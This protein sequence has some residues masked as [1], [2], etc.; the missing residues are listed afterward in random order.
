MTQGDWNCYEKY[1]ANNTTSGTTNPTSNY[2][3]CTVYYPALGYSQTYSYISPEQCQQWKDRATSNTTTT[4]NPPTNSPTI[5]TNPT[6]NTLTS[7]QIASCKAEVK[8]T[9][10]N[11]MRGCYIKYQGSGADAC[12]YAYQRLSGSYNISCS[13]TGTHAS[14]PI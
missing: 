5:Y 6:P 7:E 11:L 2:L 4:N 12:S 9:F 10:D 13:Q 14:F 8:T 3:P 1:L